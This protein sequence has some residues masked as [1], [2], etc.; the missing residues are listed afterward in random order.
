MWIARCILALFLLTPLLGCGSASTP[1]R[2]P[3]PF[4]PA[5]STIVLP[6]EVQ[7]SENVPLFAV[8]R[9]T[10]IVP[11][12]RIV[13]PGGRLPKAKLDDGR[14]VPISIRRVAVHAFSP[15]LGFASLE[16]AASRWIGPVGQW[17]DLHAGANSPAGTVE[18]CEIELPPD[19][20][21]H[22][23][24]LDS[25]HIDLAWIPAEKP[26]KFDIPALPAEA[27]TD[28][29]VRECLRIEAM[30]P[31][32][33]WRSVLLGIKPAPAADVAIPFEPDATEPIARPAAP[34]VADLLAERQAALWNHALARLQ[35]AD[36]AL[37]SRVLVECTRVVQIDGAAARFAPAW[38]DAS[39]LQGLLDQLLIDR[40]SPRALASAATAWLAKRTPACAWVSDDAGL[41]DADSRLPLPR[42]GVANLGDAPA[43][44]W[45]GGKGE[46][47]SPELFTIPPDRAKILAIPALSRA[48]APMQD[49][50]SVE[51]HVGS[52]ATLLA[53][54]R[55]ALVARPPGLLIAPTF[56]DHSASSWK[57]SLSVSPIPTG[58]R[59]QVGAL[60]ARLV[61]EAGPTNVPSGSGWSIY[62]EVERSAFEHQTIRI[63][64]GP[65][66]RPTHIVQ[67][68]LPESSRIPESGE[69]VATVRESGARDSLLPGA[70]IVP[71]ASHWSL[72]LPIPNR[73]V[74][75]PGLV[76]FGVE[77][78]RGNLRSSWPRAV[79]PWATEPSRASVDLT[80]W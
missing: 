37:Y 44:G 6:P 18:F 51:A 56:L 73:A 42:V 55:L 5:Q 2:A 53:V 16:S 54:N 45:A 48:N 19:A 27:R 49:A 29:F 52:W 66:N 50:L 30:N 17:S 11:A 76:R 68:D 1:A 7:P 70:Q 36:E 59:S 43:L 39:Q 32:A 80:R 8:F 13:G 33:R 38:A 24:W 79:F 23:L 25:Q 77:H 60:A 31:F 69:A 71:A 47:Q 14:D 10:L 35:R 65:I 3:S 40:D 57:Q 34:P 75:R 72:R 21:G 28:P 22:W 9:Q 67:V 26:L 20:I 4:G 74:E 58:E 78:I 46:S 12:S 62:M 61:R 15:T 63:F 64:F 41:L